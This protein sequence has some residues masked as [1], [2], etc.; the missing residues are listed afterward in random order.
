MCKNNRANALGATKNAIL[1]LTLNLKLNLTLN[2]KLNLN[3][4]LNLKLEPKKS[5]NNT[6]TAKTITNAFKGTLRL[7]NNVPT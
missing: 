6:T 7:D 5:R 1:N 2:L 4:T 3:L